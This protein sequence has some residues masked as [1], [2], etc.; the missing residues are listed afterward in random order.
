MATGGS[1]VTYEQRVGAMFLSC[2]LTHNP[3]PIF[4]DCPVKAVSFQ[5]SHD[6][7]RTDDILVVCSAGG[8]RRK[9]AIQIKRRFTVGN[10]PYCTRVFRRFWEDFNARDRF[11]S[12]KDAIVL[13]TPLSTT[14]L[15]S[16]TRLL[17]CARDS[18]DAED[19]K[20][21]LEIPRFVKGAGGH[22]GTIRHILEATKVTYDVD[23]E[24]V[25][26][27][28][29]SLHVQSLDF[30]QSSSQSMVN[31][32]DMLSR[33]ADGAGIANVADVAKATW[34]ELVSVAASSASEAQTL[35]YYDLPEEMREK[36]RPNSVPMQI[37]LHHTKTTLG[38]IRTT[39]AGAVTLPRAGMITEAVTALAGSRVV[40]LTGPAGSGKSVL[41]KKVIEQELGDRLRLS[42]RAEEFAHAHLDQALPSSISARSLEAIIK[43]EDKVL[44]HLESL[45][46][47]LES[48]TRDALRHLVAMAECHPHVSLLLTCRDDDMD[49]AVDAFFG[50][51]Q[52]GCR[53][54]RVPPLDKEDIRQV[55]EEVPALNVL[56]SRPES[57]Q[58]MDTPYVL[59]MAAR[60]AWP[61]TRDIPSSMRAFQKKWW[62]DMVRRDDKNPS[63]LAQLREQALVDLAMRRARQMRPF[64]TARDIDP[65]TLHALR[66]DGLIIMGDEGLAA[67]AHDVIE[68]WAV[69]KHVGLLAAESEWQA[70]VM[71]KDLG[72]FP[73][74]RRGFR[75]W[76]REQLDADSVEADRFVLAAYGN[77]SLPRSFREDVLISILLSVSVG[78]FVSRQKDRLLEDDAQLL[79]KMVHLMRVACTK[80][81]DVSGDQPTLQYMLPEPEGKAWP[82]LLRMVNENLDRLLPRHFNQL[83]GLLEDWARGTKSSAMPDGAV[84]AVR[85]AHRLLELSWDHHDNGLRERI[86]RIIASVPKADSKSFLN[87]VE[88]AS[89]KS[90]WSNALLNEFRRILTG[91]DGLPACRDHPEAMV[92]FC[93]V[94][95]PHTGSRLWCSGIWSPL[96]FRIQ[97]R[98][99]R[100]RQGGLPPPQCVVRSVL[101]TA[102]IP[103]RGRASTGVG[104]RQLCGESVRKP[105]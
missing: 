68:D 26:R 39:I 52:M 88:L 46:R 82:A 25:W 45:E 34:N 27:F 83:L 75:G 79:V 89:S 76:L 37:L 103:S 62:S 65:E 42:F 40:A 17:D 77:D 49:K 92:K 94:A 28:L 14:N 84:P 43:S 32:M 22:Y 57:G 51:G 99:A 12:D 3:S 6:G 63:G 91:P 95:A 9:I 48:F 20:N 78:D 38:D 44:I 10:N 102:D 2:L 33:S 58:I 56:L 70:H 93:N 11:D 64:A 97:V 31:I 50:Q 23:D 53:T 98:A 61:D 24:K 13:A 72:T 19:L 74:V 85:V 86:F 81:P 54:I 73:A 8:G 100:R 101:G 30:A 21:R 35:R 41:A 80:T 59:D 66:S 55:V 36:H 90:G 87:L 104:S 67:P 16:L 69:M 18:R 7:W 60:M 29:R 1:G 5:T 15:N 105:V 4:P 47:I 71:V 96:L